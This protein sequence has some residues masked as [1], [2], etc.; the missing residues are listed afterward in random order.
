[1]QPPGPDGDVVGYALD[2]GVATITLNRPDVRNAQNSALLYA[3]DDAF[4]RFAQDD[5]ADVAILCAAGPNFSS[6]HDLGTAGMDYDVH[7]PR[8]G[9]W[10]DH[11]GKAGAE[12]WMAHEEEMY[13]GLCRRW[14]DMPKPTVAMVQGACI[15]GGLML[16]WSCDLIV[17][18]D[19]AYFADPVVR[20]GVPGVELF[21]HPWE[22]GPRQAKEFL[23]LGE[24]ISAARAHEIGMVNRVVPAADLV[25]HTTELARR[26]A[27]M[28]RMGLALAKLAVNRCQEAMGGRAGIDTA[29][30]LHQLA[31]AHNA[32]V[33]GSPILGATAA[34]TPAPPTVQTAEASS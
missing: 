9:T 26:I 33:A 11:V 14:Y 24:P 27:G 21:R 4:Q 2:R 22:L 34:R 7:Y 25:A 31:H 15:A 6:G 32:L 29:F 16:A 12:I 30:G 18:A 23:F 1:M 17:A 13:L 19:D 20:M 8:R 10:C 28:P 3:L 5:G